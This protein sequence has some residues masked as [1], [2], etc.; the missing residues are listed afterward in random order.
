MAEGT[1]A[2]SYNA[3]NQPEWFWSGN[4][5]GGFM[6]FGYDPLGRC[7]KR[8][9]GGAADPA[10][11]PATYFYYDGTSLIQEGSS[12]S[13]ISQVYM[14]GNHVD[15]I[16]ADFAV[17]NNQWTYHSADA[18]GHGMFL[19]D[20][21]GALAEQYEYD[22]F[23]YPHCYSVTNGWTTDLPYSSFG[24]RFLF[25]GREWLSELKLYDYRARLYNPELGRFMQPD[26]KEFAAGDYNLYRYCHNDPVNRTDPTGLRDWIW[27]EQK[28]IVGRSDLS[29][30]VRLGIDQLQQKIDSI[31]RAEAKEEGKKDSGKG[32]A[33]QTGQKRATI[34]RFELDHGIALN[35]GIYRSTSI[36][37]LY[38]VRDGRGRPIS[39]THFDEKVTYSDSRHWYYSF[40]LEGGSETDRMGRMTDNY[41]QNFYWPDGKVTLTQTI[42][43]P[44]LGEA[45]FK[46]TMHADGSYTGD[47]QEATFH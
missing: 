25:T 22:A 20:G 7:V 47:I 13:T 46:T 1:F 15:D 10:A 9:T 32:D 2:A 5:N 30:N 40:R 17:A 34:K 45:R 4:V 42:L 18:R 41:R 44:A 31:Q 24:N 43:N 38:L 36:Y 3:L 29:A 19:T 16:V 14:L 37:W 12:A 8:W 27:D 6:S 39:N 26:P 33:G 28:Y 21:N 35:L 23:G 11:N